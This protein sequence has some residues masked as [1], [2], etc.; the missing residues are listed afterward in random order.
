MEDIRFHQCVRLARFENDRTISFIPPDGEFELMSYRLAT[1]VT[2]H[3]GLFSLLFP[4]GV[5]VLLDLCVVGNLHHIAWP[6]I[7]AFSCLFGCF[8]LVWFCLFLSF[9]ACLSFWCVSLKMQVRPLIWIEAHVE[10]HSHSRIEYFVKVRGFLSISV[11]V[12]LCP[13]FPCLCLFILTF[14]GS[15]VDIGHLE[16]R[17]DCVALCFHQSYVMFELLCVWFVNCCVGV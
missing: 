3:G 6:H 13:V 10:P 11:S 1:H 5:S 4:R 8:R 14:S 7:T 17:F 9:L 16:Q 2:P 15:T 12:C